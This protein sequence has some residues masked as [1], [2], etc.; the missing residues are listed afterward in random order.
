MLAALGLF[1]MDNIHQMNALKTLLATCINGIAVLTFV[2]AR[3]VDWPQAIVMVLGAIAGGYAGA[4]GARHIDPRYVR[5][6]VV[7]VGCAMTVYF[8][9]RR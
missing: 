7:L 9:T 6:F 8:F 2:V 1:G 3:A 4:A 5:V